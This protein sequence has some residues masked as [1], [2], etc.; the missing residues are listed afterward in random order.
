VIPPLE[1]IE[2]VHR[3]PPLVLQLTHDDPRRDSNVSS[4]SNQRPMGQ[5]RLLKL[6]S[7]ACG[8]QHSL[9]VLVC[10][11]LL[12]ALHVV[13]IVHVYPFIPVQDEMSDLMKE[14]EPEVVV[15]EVSEAQ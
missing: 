6:A 8:Q 7:D 4:E 10:F 9:G 14:R 5:I 11:L 13:L 2:A 1:V 15:R 3:H 12:L